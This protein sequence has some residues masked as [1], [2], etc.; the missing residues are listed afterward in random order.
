MMNK[1]KKMVDG[2]KLTWIMKKGMLIYYIFRKCYVAY[3]GMYVN[4]F[5]EGFWTTLVEDEPV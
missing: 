4:G 5:K 2:L 1:E 3:S